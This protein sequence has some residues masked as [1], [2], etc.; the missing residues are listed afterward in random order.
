MFKIGSLINKVKNIHSS[1]LINS[2]NNIIN[3]YKYNYSVLK[4]NKSNDNNIESCINKFYMFNVKFNK[5]NILKEGFN[6]I[7][8]FLKVGV[9]KKNNVSMLSSILFSNNNLY[10]HPLTY[11]ALNNKICFNN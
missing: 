10:S 8:D 11:V 9:L 6:D 5:E 7:S 2:H 4:N 1:N 3:P